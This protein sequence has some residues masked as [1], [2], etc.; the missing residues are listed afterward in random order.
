[1]IREN[2]DQQSRSRKST[3]LKTP[4]LQFLAGEH[5][6]RIEAL[7]PAPHE[8]FFALPTARRHA[9][10]ILLSGLGGE[11]KLSSDRLVHFIERQKDRAVAELLVGPSYSAGL[12][13]MLAKC[14]EILWSRDEYRELLDLFCAEN[15][16][17]VLRHL[18]TISQVSL[19]PVLILPAIL[20]CAKVISAVPH[21]SAAYDLAD[22]F[23]IIG[24]IKGEAAQ[25]HSAERWCKAKNRQSLFALAAKDLLPDR[26]VTY[27]PAPVLPEPF[28]PVT[29]VKA[30]RDTALEFTNCLEDYAWT[31]AKGRMAVYVWHGSPIAAVAL[32]WNVD[33]WRLAEAE[34]KANAELEEAPLRDI[35]KAVQAHGVRTGS[36]VEAISQRL[37][38]HAQPHEITAYEEDLKVK[39]FRDRLDLGDL[40]Q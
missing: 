13:K 25:R 40:W 20:R 10:A 5:A 38:R 28:E 31:V 34:T 17:L 32:I 33:G 14:G 4:L 39:S 22:A 36:S 21:L 8:G 2:T 1:M 9:I 23:E 29:T 19:R 7:W 18:E 3:G 11:A 24:R 26:P 37:L 12:I 35:V 30:L 6:T 27:S 16:N 15:S